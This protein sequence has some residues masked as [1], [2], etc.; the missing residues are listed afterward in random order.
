[1][2]NQSKIEPEFSGDVEFKGGAGSANTGTD[3]E[4]TFPQFVRAGIYHELNDQWA[5]LG[6]VGWEDWSDFE[7]INISTGQG[8]KK[9]PRNWDDTYKFAPG[10]I[11]V[12][13]IN[14]C[15]SSALPMTRPLWIQMIAHRICP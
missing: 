2:N 3:T 4:I 12:R 1:M 5:V 6:T 14:G 7:D 8:S 15:C 10:S 11:T 13:L 9:I